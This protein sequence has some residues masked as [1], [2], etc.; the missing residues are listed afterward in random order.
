MVCFLSSFNRT[1]SRSFYGVAFAIAV[2]LIG[3]Q[4]LLRTP[5]VHAV[6]K[7]ITVDA[8]IIVKAVIQKS[9]S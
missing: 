4:S 6:E 2:S 3:H 7:I 8:D 1:H 5:L 9:K